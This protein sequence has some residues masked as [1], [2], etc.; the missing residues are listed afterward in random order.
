[1][2]SVED[3]PVELDVMLQVLYSMLSIEDKTQEDEVDI[4]LLTLKLSGCL[5]GM[6]LAQ[7][8]PEDFIDKCQ[9]SAIKALRYYEVVMNES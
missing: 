6:S 4:E 7:N 3:L 1:M 9:A 2:R 8:Y 5:V